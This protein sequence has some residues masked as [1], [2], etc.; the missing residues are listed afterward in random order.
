V[1]ARPLSCNAPDLV[2]QAFVPRPI[3][4]RIAKDGQVL[5]QRRN[6]STKTVPEDEIEAVLAERFRY[7]S[8]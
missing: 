8:P 3:W 5:C 2:Q 4:T 6:N 7:G 1:S